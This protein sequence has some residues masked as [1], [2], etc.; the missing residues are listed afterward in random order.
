MHRELEPKSSED[1]ANGGENRIAS[2]P[3]FSAVLQASSEHAC[4][5]A[6]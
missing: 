1:R 5:S 6:C 3:L 4:C 2:S